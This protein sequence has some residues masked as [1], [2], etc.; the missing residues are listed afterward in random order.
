MIKKFPLAEV[1]LD[2]IG[3]KFPQEGQGKSKQHIIPQEPD[4]RDKRGIGTQRRV[5][6]PQTL[7]S[8]NAQ[9]EDER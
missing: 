3:K 1:G 5:R 7:E 4:K 2:I 9:T 8:F 6:I